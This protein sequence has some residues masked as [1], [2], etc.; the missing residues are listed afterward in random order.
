MQIDSLKTD[1][2]KVSYLLNLLTAR[3][4]GLAAE[5]KEFET[6]RRDLLDRNLLERQNLDDLL[7]NWLTDH[8]NL[9]S[10]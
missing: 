3:A 7:P 2:D 6:L 4:T 9:D 1:F 8:R 10:F 5:N